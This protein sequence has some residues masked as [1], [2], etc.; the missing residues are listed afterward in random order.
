MTVLFADA[1][2]VN[3]EVSEGQSFEQFSGWAAQRFGLPDGAA[4]AYVWEGV[5]ECGS[6]WEGGMEGEKRLRGEGSGGVRRRKKRG[7]GGVSERVSEVEVEGSGSG[8]GSGE[9]SGRVSE[10]RSE[11]DRHNSSSNSGVSECSSGVI[12]V[13]PC[14]EFFHS[15]KPEQRIIR[16]VHM[17]I[18]TQCGN[19][20]PSPIHVPHSCHSCPPQNQTQSSPLIVS[21]PINDSKATLPLPLN[22]WELKYWYPLFAIVVLSILLSEGGGILQRLVT[23]YHY[24]WQHWTGSSLPDK[25]VVDALTTLAAYP[26]TTFFIRRA[27]NPD[28]GTCM[29]EMMR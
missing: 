27:M 21:E 25:V 11:K 23:S 26:V 14:F 8:R 3:L 15:I 10:R 12:E 4:L 24:I 1:S 19:S 28:T 2:A 16:V 29:S 18:P 20:L 17:H 7:E 22:H 6:E 5:S 9:Y 13:I